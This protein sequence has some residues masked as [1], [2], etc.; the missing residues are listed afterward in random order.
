VGSLISRPLPAYEQ[1]KNLFPFDPQN[2][3]DR[4]S[5]TG[6]SIYGSNLEMYE[7]WE[8]DGIPHAYA[9]TNM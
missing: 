9:I 5:L 8:G 4:N 3:T 1:K 6:Q 2:H 7:W